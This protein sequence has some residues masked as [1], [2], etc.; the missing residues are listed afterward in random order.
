MASAPPYT[1]ASYPVAADP[2]DGAEGLAA[3]QNGRQVQIVADTLVTLLLRALTGDYSSAG[4]GYEPGVS[5][6]DALDDRLSKTGGT[7]SGLLNMGGNRIEALGAADN[8]G[9]GV[10]LGFLKDFLGTPDAAGRVQYTASLSVKDALDRLL[11]A[12]LRI[13][14][15]SVNPTQAEIGSTVSSVALAWSISGTPTAQTIDGASVPAGSRSA[16]I[17]NVSASHTYALAITDATAPGG[18]KSDSASASIAFLNKGHAGIINKTDDATITSA[19]VNGMAQAWFAD[20]TI[21]RSLSFTTAAA[22]YLWYSQPASLPIPSAFKVGG[23]A[24]TPVS[25][26]RSHMTATGQT[27]LYRDFLLSDLIAAGTNVLLEV[28]A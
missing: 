16:T 26:T 21:S 8:D 24:V 23:F 1:I 7:L 19:D 22:G 18:A 9:D 4:I 3:W 14:G 17:T 6:Q 10:S 5:V 27:V 25:T 28:I 13:T 2:L 15:M 20:G 12:G 11:Y